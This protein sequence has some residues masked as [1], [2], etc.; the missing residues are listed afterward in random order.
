[1]PPLVCPSC[2]HVN[3]EVATYCYFDGALL[4]AAAGAA[5][6]NQHNRLAREFVFPSGR[7][8]RTYDDFVAGCQEEWAAARDMLRR[9]MFSQY[10]AS[11][12]RMDLVRA[13]QEAQG[14]PDPDIRLA[15]FLGSLPVS[16]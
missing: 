11:L 10:F 14:A 9:G 7:Q 4:N 1:M 6:P 12:R 15:T 3:P 5:A 2:R 16:N 8:C 13:T